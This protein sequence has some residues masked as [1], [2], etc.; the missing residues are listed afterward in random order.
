[1][2]LVFDSKIFTVI[3][4]GVGTGSGYTL[5]KPLSESG[6]LKPESPVVFSFFL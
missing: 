4:G 3:N 6:G 1:M 5:S 2:I